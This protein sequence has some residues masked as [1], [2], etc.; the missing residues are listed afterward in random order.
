MFVDDPAEVIHRVTSITWTS[1]G[2][3]EPSGRIAGIRGTGTVSG[4]NG[5]SPKADSIQSEKDIAAGQVCR[6]D[7]DPRRIRLIEHVE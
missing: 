5:Y 1:I 4:R 6:S 2:E 3:T 7:V